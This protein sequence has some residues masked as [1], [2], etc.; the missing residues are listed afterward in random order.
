MKTTTNHT[1][2]THKPLRTHIANIG[3]MCCEC[4]CVFVVNFKVVF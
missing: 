1:I 2:I 3:D 4:F